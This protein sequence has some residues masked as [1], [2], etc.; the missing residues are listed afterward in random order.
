MYLVTHHNP[1]AGIAFS[2]VGVARTIEAAKDSVRHYY[3]GV[4]QTWVELLTS[5]TQVHIRW[6]DKG[7]GICYIAQEVAV[8]DD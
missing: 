3:S 6:I 7:A 5:D 8:L 4:P 1:L 2:V